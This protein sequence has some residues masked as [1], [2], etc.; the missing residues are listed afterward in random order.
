MVGNLHSYMCESSLLDL[1]ANSARA[2]RSAF[3][4]LPGDGELRLGIGGV[5]LRAMGVIDARGMTSGTGPCSVSG[6]PGN[7]MLGSRRRL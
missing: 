7:P 3:D 1:A 4:G 2:E 6:D 5:F